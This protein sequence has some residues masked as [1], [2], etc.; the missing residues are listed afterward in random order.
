M[1]ARGASALRLADPSLL[2]QSLFVGGEWVAQAAGGERLS[3][4]NPATGAALASLPRGGRAETR[5]AIDAAAE[6]LPAWAATPPNE[7]AGVLRRWGAAVLDNAEDLAVIM[8]AEQ[9]KPLAEAKGEV[10]YAASFLD[11]FADEARR[12]TGEALPANFIPG[13]RG[14]VL[15]QP[16]GVSACVTPFNFPLAMITRKVGA[17]A[18]AGCPTV[19]KPCET[20][21]LSALAL[22]A[23]AERAGL[24][25]G[26]LSVVAG[27]AT[28][29]GSE[30][31]ESP[32]VR[33][34]SFTG[35]TPVG[36]LLLRQCAG[37]VKRTS[38][39]LGG[40]A[41]FLVF[42]DADVD[43]AL[44]GAVAC[45]Y[46]NSGQTCV[47]ANRFIVHSAVYDAFA[48]GLAE[49]AAALVVGDG[50]AGP[51]DQGPLISEAAVAKSEAHVADAVAKGA[52]VLTGGKRHALGG[53]FFEP[54]VLVDCTPDTRVFREETFGPVAALFRFD[55][56]AEAIALANDTDAGLAA[57][58]YTR[59]YARVA[60]VS[61]RLEYGMVG[62]N[63]GIVSSAAA[64]FGGVKESGLGREGGSTGTDEYLESKYVCVGGVDG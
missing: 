57:Y 4:T 50:L 23:L 40:N 25:K 15:R 7:R 13:S 18:A 8:T 36:K 49:R 48:A 58:A 6:A 63:T 51:T 59:D 41:P 64:P 24:P 39:E 43:K 11:W 37:T 19:C 22:A 2:R 42:D 20:V 54:T 28:E 32:V 10:A 14:V 27:D 30:L 5:R 12:A 61:E 3:V 16:V 34:L 31:C 62:M 21:P 53:T 26:V 47:C 35:S 55:T 52:R 44:S 45:K 1:A 9:G 33:K 17:A 46:R 29:I 56:E 38:M 60:R